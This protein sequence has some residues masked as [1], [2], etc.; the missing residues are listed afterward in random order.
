M[1]LSHPPS[2]L[3]LFL[4]IVGIVAVAVYLLARG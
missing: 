2:D 4:L 1:T 3:P